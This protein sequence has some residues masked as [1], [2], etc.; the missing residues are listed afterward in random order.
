MDGRRQIVVAARHANLDKQ[1][2]T[3]NIRCGER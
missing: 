1:E 3:S 2:D